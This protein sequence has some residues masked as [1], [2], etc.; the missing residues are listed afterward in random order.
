MLE[1]LIL[2]VHTLAAIAMVGLIMIQHGKGADMG[3]SFGSG[4][5]A[6]VLG[7]QGGGNLLTH[8]TAVLATVFFVTSLT[9]GYFAKQHSMTLE[10]LVIDEP[11]V[12]QVITTKADEEI[13][14]MIET[15]ETVEASEVPAT[16][17]EI[18]AE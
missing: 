10:E 13:P 2:I 15:Q 17:G 16:E 5:S 7:V 12:E 1:Q 4:S 14:A 3:A 11:A 18:P 8:A 6:T 9:L